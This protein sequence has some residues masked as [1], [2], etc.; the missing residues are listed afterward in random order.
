VFDI[1]I[2]LFIVTTSVEVLSAWC[3]NVGRFYC[4]ARCLT[5]LTNGCLQWSDKKLYSGTL[6]KLAGLFQKNFEIYADYKVGGDSKVTEQI[7]AAGPR[8]E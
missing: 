6:R 4:S 8:L 1:V 7:L 3:G 5:M 2:C